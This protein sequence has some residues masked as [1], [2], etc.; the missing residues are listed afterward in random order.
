MTSLSP[1]SGTRCVVTGGLGFIGSNLAIALAGAGA[2][3]TVIDSLVPR[4]G[5]NRRNLDGT[6]IAVVEADIAERE[7]VRPLV[8]EATHIFNLAG[9]V[10]H[11]DSMVDPVTDLDLNTRSHLVFLETLREVNPNVVMVYSSTRQIYGRPRYLP[12][13]EDHPIAPVDVNGVSKHAS[14]QFHLLYAQVY[15]LRACSLR[16]TNVY[17]PRLRLKGNHQGFLPVFIRTALQG[18]TIAVYGNGSQ[19]RDC[20]WIGDVV[21]AMTA[22]ALNSEMYGSVFNLGGEPHSLLHIAQT[23]VEVAGTGSVELVPFP[24]ER[25]SIDIGSYAGDHAKAKRVL[26]WEPLVELA[27]GLARTLDYYRDRLAW[28]L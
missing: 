5:G 3:V 17:G 1:F 26:G 12:V 6:S 23:L 18:G 4:H 19:Q 7:I 14:E 21:E 24:P 2:D 27:D 16:L 9:Q 13:D 15:G 28:Y 10:S 25:E 22:A 20:L 11:I 8:A